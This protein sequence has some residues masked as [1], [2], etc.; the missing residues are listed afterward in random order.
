MLPRNEF[1]LAEHIREFAI[2]EN[3]SGQLLGCGALHIYTP[4]VAE[5]RSLG[6]DPDLKT[7]GIGRRIV[8]SLITEGDQLGLHSV[9]AFTYVPGFFPQAPLRLSRSFR[10]PPQG[11]EGLPPLPKTPGM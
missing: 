8:E 5:V 11:V 3:E 10:A 4:T 6:V 9:F 7:Q 2:A 1:E